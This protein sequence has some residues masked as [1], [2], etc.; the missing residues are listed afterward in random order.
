MKENNENFD[1]LLKQSVANTLSDEEMHIP[2]IE[3]EMR[4]IANSVHPYTL[5]TVTPIAKTR[6][7]TRNIAAAIVGLLILSGGIYAAIKFVPRI[8]GGNSAPEQT[9]GIDTV[10]RK[11]VEEIPEEIVF[12][13]SYLAEMLDTISSYYDMRLRFAND[14]LKTMRLHYNF[15]PAKSI[16]KVVRDLNHF[17]KITITCEDSVIY[18]D[19]RKE[20]L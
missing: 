14:N 3:E 16:D 4:R 8:A 11:A 19:S 10:T 6:L 17:K 5:P 20:E 7:Y 12:D 1:I 2:D 15:C 18:V 13:N 9:E